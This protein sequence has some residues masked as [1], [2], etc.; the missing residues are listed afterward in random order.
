MNTKTGRLIAVGDIHGH[1][2]SLESL[3]KKINPSSGDKFI[4]L[5]DYINNGPES[6][7][8]IDFLIDIKEKFT[9][10]IFLK[11]NHE[12]M[13]IDYISGENKISFLSNGG[14]STLRTYKNSGAVEI[15]KEHR[16]FFEQLIPYH[17]E[18]NYTFV[19]AGLKPGIPIRENELS[20]MLWIRDEFIYSDYDWGKKVFFGHTPF[21]VPFVSTNKT[22]L[23]CDIN[24]VGLIVCCD[25]ENELF[26]FSDERE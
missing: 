6:R 25:V 15:P 21:E 1:I 22:G 3:F 26:W 2:R 7:K 17:E 18:A 12:Q 20:T 8:V 5:G 11:G 24:N 4:F 16:S 9:G 13:F 23:N 10:S 14:Y 19:H